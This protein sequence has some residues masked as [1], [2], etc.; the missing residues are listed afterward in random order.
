MAPRWCTVTPWRTG[1]ENNQNRQRIAY[2]SEVMGRAHPLVSL[3]QE[4]CP[5][6][7][8]P[9]I[10]CARV[11]QVQTDT[12]FATPAPKVGGKSVVNERA[13]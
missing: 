7:P 4:L 8:S 3:G 12:Q 5:L 6:E 9:L 1:I 13:K 11:V 10:T 2:P